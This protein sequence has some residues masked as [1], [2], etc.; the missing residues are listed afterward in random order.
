MA[1]QFELQVV[2][3]FI[4]LKLFSLRTLTWAVPKSTITVT[5]IVVVA[6][7]VS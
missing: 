6:Y 5:V 1:S 2:M 3:E 7:K 4:D